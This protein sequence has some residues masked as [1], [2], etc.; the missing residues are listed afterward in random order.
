MERSSLLNKHVGVKLDNGGNDLLDITCFFSHRFFYP[1]VGF[2]ALICMIGPVAVAVSRGRYWC[3]NVRPQGNFYDKIIQRLSR[4]KSIPVV[5]KM[6]GFRRFMVM[7]IFVVFSIQMYVA[8]GDPSA[9]GDI[10]IRIIFWTTVIG[11]VIGIVFQQRAW[12][13]ICPLG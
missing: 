7:F 3:G 4:Q 6:E 2:V 13:R 12:C 9:M 1:V 8:W 10:F 11:V 5:F